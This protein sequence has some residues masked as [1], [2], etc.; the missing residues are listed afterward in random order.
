MGDANSAPPD[1]SHALLQRD[2]RLRRRGEHLREPTVAPVPE[3]ARHDHGL[4]ADETL[5]HALTDP[6]HDARDLVPQHARQCHTPPERALHDERVVVRKAAGD[7]AQQ[8]LARRGLWVGQNCV[9][10]SRLRSG[11]FKN[12]GV[13]GS[14]LVGLD[15]GCTMCA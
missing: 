2:K 5:G 1:R 6:A 10:Q 7:H 14:I 8:R 12:Y 3:V 11:G 4:S 15:S 13:H 9:A